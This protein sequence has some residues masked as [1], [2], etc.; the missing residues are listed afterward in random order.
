LNFD[1]PDVL[2]LPSGSRYPL[3]PSALSDV[4][5]LEYLHELGITID[6][7]SM[8][9]L[10]RK[11]ATARDIIASFESELPSGKLFRAAEVDFLWFCLTTLWVRWFPEIPSIEALHKQIHAGY[12]LPA[13]KKCRMWLRAWKHFLEL[14][15]KLKISSVEEFDRR[16]RGPNSISEW[17]ENLEAELGFSGYKETN[18][19][20]VATF[21][22][23]ILSK[24]P[25]SRLPDE[26]TE[27]RRKALANCYFLS[28]QADKSEANLKDWLNDDPAWGSG[29]IAWSNHYFF[30]HDHQNLGLAEEL[31]RKALS[32]PGVRS[33]LEV[34]V[35]LAAILGEQGKDDESEKIMRE[36]DSLYRKQNQGR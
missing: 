32:V 13:F 30:R 12:R 4:D 20:A 22:E 24:F 33:Q 36:V 25:P 23:E 27:R 34:M 16:F 11:F 15:D 5:L 3:D 9:E 10:C 31:M 6:R 26:S 14:C 17:I 21:Y 8:T 29:W 2:T 28:D 35:H 18:K 19:E 1:I 7:E